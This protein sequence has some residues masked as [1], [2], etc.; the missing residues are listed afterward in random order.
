MPTVTVPTA[1]DPVQAS[2]GTSVAEA[3]NDVHDG[4]LPFVGALDLHGSTN[5]IG[6]TNIAAE[7]AGSGGCMLVPIVLGASIE[8]VN[9]VWWNGSAASA[10]TAEF[11]LYKD[12]GSTTLEYVTGSAANT[13]F[14][15]SS[16]GVRRVGLDGGNLVVPPGMYWIAIRNTSTSISF[17]LGHGSNTAD[18]SDSGA[19]IARSLY[20]ASADALGSTLDVSSF[21][22]NI[23]INMV[24]LDGAVF[25]N[26]GRLNP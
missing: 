25:G 5:Q 8:V 3:I 11:R 1:G 20:Y 16:A 21:S 10:R 14:T 4:R 24:G 22:A 18:W 19:D 15:P 6:N 2:W 7:S 13:S 26:T 12:T 17:Q 23:K 9:Y